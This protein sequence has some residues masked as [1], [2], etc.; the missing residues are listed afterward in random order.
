MIA[1]DVNKLSVKIVKLKAITTVL[2][3]SLSYLDEELSTET[4]D[5]FARMVVPMSVARSFIQK[6][7]KITKYLRPMHTA[8]VLYGTHVI[9][10]ERHPLGNFGK[11]AED[12]MFDMN[13]WV[14]EC[15]KN[16]DTTLKPMLQDSHK[17]WF[18]DGRYIYSFTEGNTPAALR[19]GEYLTSDGRFRKVMATALDTQVLD[20]ASKLDLVVRSCMAYVTDSGKFGISPPIWKNLSSI[21]GTQIGKGADADDESDDDVEYT[22]VTKDEYSF[23]KIDSHLSVNLNFVLKAGQQIG[24]T[25][26]Y[27][28][29]EPL[30]LPRLM[31]ELHTTN[32]PNVPSQV[33]AT[34]N[35][36]LQFTHAMAWLLGLSERSTDLDT[37]IAMR[38]LMK[39]LSTKGV[40]ES[41]VLHA[42]KVFQP[43]Q[44]V[45][46]IA[47][48]PLDVLLGAIDYTKVSIGMI[49]EQAR[50]SSKRKQGKVNGRIFGLGLNEED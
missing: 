1:F 34:Y 5:V 22:D 21:G 39:Y 18:F 31:I 7:D 47:T 15:K 37:Y 17:Q 13:N 40:F 44:S 9:A 3:G 16:I 32:L 41:D 46:T 30:Q 8:V 50:A 20:D 49:L 43:G 26:G 12:S 2:G 33:K 10:M 48:V 11:L 24:K 36:G 35:T 6:T 42:Q 38:S 27:E 14:P 19:E 4:T 29:V 25:F 45:D 28:M 23:D